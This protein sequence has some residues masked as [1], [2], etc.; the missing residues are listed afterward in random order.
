MIS[1]NTQQPQCKPEEGGLVGGG[2]VHSELGFCQRVVTYKRKTEL[3]GG[4]HVGEEAGG[5][6]KRGVA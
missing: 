1:K 2:G 4:I 6:E 3:I 5:Q